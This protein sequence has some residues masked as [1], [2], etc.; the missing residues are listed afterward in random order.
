MSSFLLVMKAQARH[1]QIVVIDRGGLIVFVV[2]DLLAP[3]RVVA[4]EV[5]MSVTNLGEFIAGGKVLAW[6]GWVF[7][8]VDLLIGELL[9]HQLD[10]M[11]GSI[12]FPTIGCQR[13]FDGLLAKC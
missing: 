7:I 9:E 5:H 8:L 10:G 4:V 13:A 11:E 12:E 1:P 3:D 6:L 2:A